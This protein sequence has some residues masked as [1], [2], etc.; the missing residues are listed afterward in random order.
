M[1]GGGDYKGY[2]TTDFPDSDLEEELGPSNPRR[3]KPS[4]TNVP[5][6]CGT[7][8][9][10]AIHTL[11]DSD[12]FKQEYLHTEPCVL[13]AVLESL[14]DFL[15][16]HKDYTPRDKYVLNV[17][18]KQRGM[19]NIEGFINLYTMQDY[20]GIFDLLRRF[21]CYDKVHTQAGVLFAEQL[22]EAH[23]S[24]LRTCHVCKHAVYL[25]RWYV[26]RQSSVDSRQ[27]SVC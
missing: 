8:L 19:E 11:R 6:K 2:A 7:G 16:D 21:I 17:K 3:K 25:L 5:T 18:G 24:D 20:T 26:E 1:E 14:L 4:R 9:L 15:K 27:S 22:L 12:K 10:E 13:E 23:C